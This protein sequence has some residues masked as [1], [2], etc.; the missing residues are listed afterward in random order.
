M[1]ILVGGEARSKKSNFALQRAHEY[2]ACENRNV[3]FIETAQR[4]DHKMEQ[5]ILTHQS[6][7]E[8]FFAKHCDEV[9]YMKFGLEM[10]VK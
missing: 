8:H 6:E 4:T 10:K 1:P 3:L 2:Y 5:C 9:V 7:R